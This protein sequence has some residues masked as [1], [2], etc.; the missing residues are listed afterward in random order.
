MAFVPGVPNRVPS[1]LISRRWRAIVQRSSESIGQSPGRARQSG[2]TARPRTHYTY[3]R[4]TY[5]RTAA[6]WLQGAAQRHR[7]TRRFSESQRSARSPQLWQ[8]C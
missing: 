6:L 3:E 7:E 1:P 2:T 8:L 4:N 5:E